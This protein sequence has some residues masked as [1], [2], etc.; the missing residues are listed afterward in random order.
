MNVSQGEINI[1]Q[2]T[3]VV[4]LYNEYLQNSFKLK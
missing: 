2:K 1:C 4:I 3:F